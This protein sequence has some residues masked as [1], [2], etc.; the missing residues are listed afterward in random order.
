MFYSRLKQVCKDKGTTATTVLKQLNI[1]TGAVGNW[2]K[3]SLP[4]GDILAALSTYLDVSMDYLVFGK[5]PPE[6]DTILT[7]ADLPADEYNL[8]STYREMDLVGKKLLQDQLKFL[9]ADHRQLD[10][11]VPLTNGGNCG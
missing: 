9:W 11:K 7:M 3:G 2:K 1:S 4:T 8:L 10:S 6:P 5:Q